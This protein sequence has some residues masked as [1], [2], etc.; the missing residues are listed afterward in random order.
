MVSIGALG[1]SFYEYLLKYWLL[2]AK[3]ATEVGEWYFETADAIGRMLAV[4]YGA[5]MYYV[6]I[7]NGVDT[8]D[9]QMDH[10]VLIH[11]FDGYNW[12]V[13]NRFKGLL[14]WRNVLV[15]FHHD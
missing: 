1:D 7:M 3:K 11:P 2:T 4:K 5:D 8:Y 15:G 13:L 6:R 9:E 14:R 12:Y 10:L